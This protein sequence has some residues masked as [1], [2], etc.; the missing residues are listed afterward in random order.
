MAKPKRNTIVRTEVPPGFREVVSG[1]F[2]PFHDFAAN[3][4][5][6]GIVKGIREATFGKGKQKKTINVMD[7]VSGDRPVSVSERADLRGLFR[8]AKKGDEVMIALEGR[9]KIPGQSQPMLVFRT[10]IREQERQKS[11]RKAR[12]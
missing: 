5:C 10:A 4:V 8:E 11:G 9:K 2:A 7:L 1:D 3:P 6:I 12:G